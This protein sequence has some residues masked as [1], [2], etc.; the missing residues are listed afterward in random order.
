MKERS[1][2]PLWGPTEVT[3]GA[4]SSSILRLF[5]GMGFLLRAQSS[6]ELAGDGCMTRVGPWKMTDRW[7]AGCI[8]Q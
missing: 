8:A 6:M 3:M 4:F 2:V 5:G 1:V 7:R